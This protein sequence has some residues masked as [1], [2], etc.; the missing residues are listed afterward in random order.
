MAKLPTIL[1]LEEEEMAEGCEGHP[2]Y[3]VQIYN[4]AGNF[5]E[6][7]IFY[8]KY[9]ALFYVTVKV[10]ALGH[11]GDTLTRPLLNNIYNRYKMNLAITNFLK[12]QFQE[13]KSELE[14][15]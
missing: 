4:N 1:A 11:I 14:S 7:M 12:Q 9:I 8:T 13:L 3:V 2:D 5:K 15:L 6:K 10:R